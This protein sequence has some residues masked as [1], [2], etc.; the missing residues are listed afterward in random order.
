MLEPVYRLASF[1][2]RSLPAP[3]GIA[4]LNA[5]CRAEVNSGTFEFGPGGQYKLSL[6][7]YSRCTGPGGQFS[8]GID[9]LRNTG[10]YSYARPN[11]ITHQIE[12]DE[13]D[14]DQVFFRRDE[15][16]VVVVMFSEVRFPM[17]F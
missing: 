10:T 12:D 1:N 8:V 4:S 9:T 6:I 17:P 13:F 7:R 16:N 15:L 3:I 2:G 5:D 11:V 14:L